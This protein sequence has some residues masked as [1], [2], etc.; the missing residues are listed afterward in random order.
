M[1]YDIKILCRSAG[2]NK[3]TVAGHGLSDGACVSILFTYLLD[4]TTSERC[5]L[6]QDYIFGVDHA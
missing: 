5:Q 1:L 6:T 3:L 2:N 4:T